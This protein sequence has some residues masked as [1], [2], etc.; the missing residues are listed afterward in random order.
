MPSMKGGKKSKKRR[1]R[2]GMN[3]PSSVINGSDV[4]SSTN[5][6]TNSNTNMPQIPIKNLKGGK[7]SKKRK[8]SK[9]SRPM[10]GGMNTASGSGLEGMDLK[11]GYLN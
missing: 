8:G 9:R 6:N 4:N 3:G 2:G 10:R 11:E 1:M 7:K 5:S